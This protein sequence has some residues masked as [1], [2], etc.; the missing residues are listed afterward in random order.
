[1]PENRASR[2]RLD[3]EHAGKQA[4]ENLRRKVP[5]LL[6]AG[7][8]AKAPRA[9]ES[10]RAK[11]DPCVIYKVKKSSNSKLHSQAEPAERRTAPASLQCQ[12][13]A[14]AHQPASHLPRSPAQRPAAEQI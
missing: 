11:C 5:I 4:R 6:V 10:V 2:H 13:V 9:A 1:M 14:Q 3:D 12:H 7:L 8:L